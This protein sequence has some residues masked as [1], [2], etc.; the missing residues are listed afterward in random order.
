MKQTIVPHAAHT[1]IFASPLARRT[2]K[3]AGLD[4]SSLNGSGP[5]G[6]IIKR[7]IENQQVVSV[8]PL[9]RR[10]AAYAGLELATIGGGKPHGRIV[11][12]DV[13]RILSHGITKTAVAILSVPSA[14]PPDFGQP[15]TDVPNSSVRKIIASRLLEAKQTIPHFYLTVECNIDELMSLRTKLNSHAGADYKLSVNDFVIKAVAAALKKVPA[16]NATW[17]DEAVLRYTNIDISVAV[18]TPDGLITPIIRNADK[19]GLA[20]ISNEMKVLATRAKDKKLKPEECRGGSFSISNLGMFGIK[21]FSAIINP[22]QSCILAVGKAEQRPILK[23][24]STAIATM[25]SCTL[26]VDH[27]S[28]DGAVGAEFIQAFQAIIEE[29]LSVLL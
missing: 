8:T 17:T 15:Y 7:D 13:D 1:R 16:A 14:P 22:P 26:S 11:K 10:M 20:V 12:A 5:Y 27:R 29:P 2:A 28:V 25:M 23:N 18:A 24:G 9:A 6:R 19:K 3:A 21:E 4:L